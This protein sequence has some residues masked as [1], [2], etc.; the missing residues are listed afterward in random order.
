MKLKNSCYGLAILATAGVVLLQSCASQAPRRIFVFPGL[1]TTTVAL[2][3]SLARG[4]FLDW[5]KEQL[6]QRKADSA[7]ALI[8]KS[9]ELWAVLKADEGQQAVG[10]D[11]LTAIERY[12]QGVQ[13]LNDIAAV[14]S[15]ASMSPDER[16]KAVRDAL[17]RARSY[18]EEAIALNPFDEQTRFALST[19]YEALAQRFLQDQYWGNAAEVLLMLI[20]MNG[21]QHVF[22]AR[23][24]ECFANLN[25]WQE[26][27]K[28]Y[29]QAEYVLRETAA[30]Q[31]PEN[32]PIT[33]ANVAAA[34]DSSA[35]FLYVYY[36]M[37]GNM[38]LNHEDS[39]KVDF[40]RAAELAQNDRHRSLLR[41]HYQWANWDDW[42]LTASEMR[43]SLEVYST[44][45]QYKRAADG[46]RVLLKT[47]NL[48]TRRARQEVKWRL[49]NLE[50]SHLSLPDSAIVHM[51]QVMDFYRQDSAGMALAQADT[52][53]QQYIDA[54]GVMCYNT[55]LAALE[56][57][58]REGA[59]PYFLQSLSVDWVFEAKA[60]LEVAKLLL[61]DP[62]RALPY[63]RQAYHLRQQL[64]G[65]EVEDTL[66]IL[67]QALRRQRNF[68]EA[69]TFQELLHEAR[70]GNG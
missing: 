29:Q 63:A 60:H 34:I 50:F 5:E 12:N 4:V 47:G 59:L 16:Q 66:R 30:M 22:Y 67:V 49:A 37:L 24:G 53:L 2:A 44:R 8:Q 18:L 48:R 46:Y 20:K 57:P 17:L 64:S 69:R 42:N 41:Y 35:L 23:L 38:R 21:G 32:Q 3:D 13:S 33:D 70:Q 11:T 36:Q 56:I 61:N 39:A 51:K 52:L 7:Q 28:N 58:D 55:G 14:E 62:N 6:A 40:R 9:D 19:I 68:D 54:Y 31:V 65:Q 10:Q 27:L 1:D 43:D 15:D 45:E 26:S 25:A